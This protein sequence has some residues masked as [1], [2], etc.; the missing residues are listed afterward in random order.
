MSKSLLQGPGLTIL[1]SKVFVHL[2][3]MDIQVEVYGFT[4]KLC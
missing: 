2:N 1:A 4:Q 3:T